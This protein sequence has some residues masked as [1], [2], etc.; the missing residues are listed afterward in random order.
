MLS[1]AFRRPA[2]FA[3]RHELCLGI[4]RAFAA[5]QAH[6]HDSRALRDVRSRRRGQHKNCVTSPSAVLI[7]VVP[8]SGRDR[9]PAAMDHATQSCA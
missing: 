1:P 6:V 3:Q 8:N 5:W 9:S 4:D 2:G 7:T